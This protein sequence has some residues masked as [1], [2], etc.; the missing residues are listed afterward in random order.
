[1]SL[2]SKAK[3]AKKR[4]QLKL[5]RQQEVARDVA[6]V[7]ELKSRT[8]GFAR[9]QRTKAHE[10]AFV[11]SKMPVYARQQTVTHRQSEAE[12]F[13]LSYGKKRAAV[14]G[15]ATPE[16]LQREADAVERTKMFK[17]RVAPAYN[18]G[19]LQLLSEGEVAAERRGELRRRS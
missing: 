3:A 5:Q 13:D 10:Q 1:M 14:V 9:T 16:M 19:G 11:A 12:R 7:A 6:K 2:K 17:N 18:K 15:D 8:S 4:E